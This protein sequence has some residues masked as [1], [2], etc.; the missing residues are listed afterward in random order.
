MT[1][2]E[3]VARECSAEESELWR[4]EYTEGY[5]VGR[6]DAHALPYPRVREGW[7]LPSIPAELPGETG[8]QYVARNVSQARQ[9][10]YTR[11]WL[12]Y[13]PPRW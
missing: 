9:V 1:V 4:A 12:Y 13:G 3:T 2:T 6:G 5:R 8:A 10:G 11:A 7:L